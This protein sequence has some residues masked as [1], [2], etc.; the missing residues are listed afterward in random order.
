MKSTPAESLALST[1]LVAA[2]RAQRQ[3][4]HTLALL[5]SELEE[6]RHHHALG[7]ATLREYSDKV[8]DLPWRQVLDLLR[9]GRA[10]P[11][12]HPETT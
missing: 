2:C 3:A 12:L 9:I 6:G 11:S 1:R 10:L 4:L 7:Y 5:L 8:L